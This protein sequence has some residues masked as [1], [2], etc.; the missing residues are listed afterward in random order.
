M[1]VIKE[2]S[3]RYTSEGVEFRIS[4]KNLQNRQKA[5]ESLN[6]LYISFIY[7]YMLLAICIIRN[8]IPRVGI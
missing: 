4:T 8:S 5:R 2:Y 6:F 3:Y 1:G 7:E